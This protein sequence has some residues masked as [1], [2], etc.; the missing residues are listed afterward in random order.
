MSPDI[1]QQRRQAHDF[2]DRLPPAQVPAVRGL[3]EA[4]LEPSVAQFDDEPLT[5][6]DRR[7]IRE[8]RAWFAQRGGKGVPMEEVLA[9][10]GL[11]QEDFP[12]K[13]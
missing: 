8:G 12:L 6:E 1:D 3:L 7:R 5:E 4:M 11:T 10:F 2:L 13:K 9:D